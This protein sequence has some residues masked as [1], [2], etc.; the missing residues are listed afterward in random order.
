MSHFSAR[1]F[2]FALSIFTVASSFTLEANAGWLSCRQKN[3]LLKP[4]AY[5]G[6]AGGAIGILAEGAVMISG[7]SLGETIVTGATAIGVMT[8][9][10]CAS[11]AKNSPESRITQN[12]VSVFESEDFA[13]LANQVMGQLP[14]HPQVEEIWRTTQEMDAESLICSTMGKYRDLTT[15]AALVAERMRAGGA[16]PNQEIVLE[17]E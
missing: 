5:C 3:Q 4:A 14:D 2:L 15:V 13:N 17:V 6:W 12:A 1:N 8:M 9:G 10:A 16:A 11:Q 7:G